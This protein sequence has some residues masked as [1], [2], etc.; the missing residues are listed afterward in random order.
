MTTARSNL[1]GGK[2]RDSVLA[3]IDFY[4]NNFK[5]FTTFTNVL[6]S[7]SAK[8][9]VLGHVNNWLDSDAI[10]KKLNDRNFAWL[11][12]KDTRTTIE[13]YFTDFWN[14]IDL[15]TR[16]GRILSG[17][18]AWTDLTTYRG[19]FPMIAKGSNALGDLRD[20]VGNAAGQLGTLA[21]NLRNSEQQLRATIS[22]CRS[23][24]DTISDYITET[25]KGN[26]AN[27]FDF[28]K[29]VHVLTAAVSLLLSTIDAL[30][31]AD[32]AIDAAATGVGNIRDTLN[33][34]K[35][36]LDGRLK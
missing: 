20:S 6:E 33:G 10:K 1:G 19:K 16:V 3:T 2:P 12:L 7:A 34:L 15:D 36:S 23:D 9:A 35:T 27:L 26:V 14:N 18:P 25:A 11:G 24:G 8:Q 29:V 4:F 28:G 13:D 21:T 5:G 30:D 22:K 17:L 32:N 31:R